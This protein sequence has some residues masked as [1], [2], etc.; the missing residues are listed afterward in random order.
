[1]TFSLLYYPWLVLKVILLISAPILTYGLLWFINLV[2]IKPLFDPLRNI[3]GPNGAKFESHIPQVMDPDITPGVYN[4]WR[5]RYG[6]T[7]RFHGFGK[8]DYRLLSFDKVTIYHV[9][10]KP[11][12]EKPWQTRRFLGRIIGRGIFSMEGDE[13]KAQRKIV[14]TAFKK[15]SISAMMPTFLN[16]AEELAARWKEELHKTEDKASNTVDIAHWVSRAT[17]DVMGMVGFEYDFH[18]LEDES[19]EVYSAYRRM[20]SIVDKGMGLWDVLELYLPWLRKIFVTDDIKTTNECLEVIERA[21]KDII[22]RKKAALDSFLLPK[23]R[24]ADLLTLL[25]KE[26]KIAC[27]D[28]QLSDRD[29]LDQCSTFLLAGADT[30]SVALSWC[31]HLLSQHAD[32]QSRLRK[33]IHKVYIPRDTDLSDESDD[34]GYQECTKCTGHGMF[35]CRCTSENRSQILWDAVLKLPYLDA[36]IHEALRLSPPA[37]GTIRVATQDDMLPI[38]EPLVMSDGTVKAKGQVDYIKIKKGSYI[39]IPIE[40]INHDE[41]RWGTDALLFNPERWQ[42]EERHKSESMSLNVGHRNLMTFGYGQH[43][44]VGAKLSITAMKIFL[45]V[46][47]SEFDFEPASDVTIAKCNTILTRP[48]IKGKWSAGTQ[49]PIQIRTLSK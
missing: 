2:F 26:N 14:L 22:A 48:I 16:K 6:P 3:P 40:G 11:M 15:E 20:F 32:V 19:E 8:H 17:F 33:E 47:L 37:H 29:L 4:E 23:Q 5:K 43:M 31:I 27:A 34:S 42:K 36:V 24:Q 1:M 35:A 46:L 44:C 30:L 10:T 38:S 18:A 21:G 25:I 7:F 13:H 39:H 12:Y 9:L 49:L 45:V 41:D 28:E